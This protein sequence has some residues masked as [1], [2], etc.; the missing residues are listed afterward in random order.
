MEF[1]YLPFTFIAIDILL[2]WDYMFYKISS[3]PFFLNRVRINIEFV[4]IRHDHVNYNFKVS[5]QHFLN[6]SNHVEMEMKGQLIMSHNNQIQVI[7]LC[8]MSKCSKWD[9]WSRTDANMT[10]PG[11]QMAF[12]YVLPQQHARFFCPRATGYA[13]YFYGSILLRNV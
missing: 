2:K 4:L 11:A 9:F 1:C 3:R 7:W 13:P 12:I 8:L 5:S 6:F 10:W